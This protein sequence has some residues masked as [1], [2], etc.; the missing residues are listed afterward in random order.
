MVATATD[1]NYLSASKTGSIAVV[2]GFTNDQVASKL[3][4][5]GVMPGSRIKLVRKAPFGGGFYVKVDN[6]NLAL[7]KEE[8]ESIVLK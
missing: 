1:N 4:A 6:F 2:Q 7:R 3:M 8:A 5:M